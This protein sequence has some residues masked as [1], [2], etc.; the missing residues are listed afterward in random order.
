MK[1]H[2]ILADNP[3]FAVKW[4]AT[5]LRMDSSAGIFSFTAH[6]AIKVEIDLFAGGGFVYVSLRRG[7]RISKN[8]IKKQKVHIDDI[9]KFLDEKINEYLLLEK[10]DRSLL[11]LERHKEKY[12]SLKNG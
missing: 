5:S 10:R 12:F 4:E 1:A 3:M 11:G 9:F 2:N 6:K 7:I 8:E